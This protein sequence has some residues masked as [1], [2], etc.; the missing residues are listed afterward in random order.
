[1]FIID[2]IINAIA[3]WHAAEAQQKQAREAMGVQ[4]D[5]WN[6]QRADQAPWLQAGQTTLRDLMA[7]MQAGG[8]DRQFNANS[9]AN[10]PGFQFR[11]A[12]GQKALERSA[13]A[14]GG[15]NSGGFMKSLAR[16]SQ[17]VASDEFQNAWSRNQ[18]ENT[19]RFNRLAHLAGVGQQSAQNLAG[20]GGHYAD[21][22]SQLHGALGN[23]QAA[24]AM[25]VGQGLAGG[26]RS[27]GNLA[28]SGGLPGQQ[29]FG[30]FWNPIPKQGG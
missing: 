7:Q 28:L 23:A 30:D 14:R 5:M 10:D 9:L 1:V 16:Y 6:Q 25:G 2:D 18:T 20:H 8:F 24:Q 26:V 4:R 3:S 13:A 29:G 15:L 21:S 11:M 17:G 27:I 19:G 22:M 12:E